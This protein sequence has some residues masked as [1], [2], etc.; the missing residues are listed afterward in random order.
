MNDSRYWELYHRGSQAL[1]AARVLEAEEAF[2]QA[3]LEASLQELHPLVDRAWCNWAAVRFER[4][5]TAG[6]QDGL[7]R[8][9]GTSADLKARQLAAYNLAVQLRAEDRTRPARLYA[10]MAE[11]QAAELGDQRSRAACLHMLGLL[12]IDEGRLMDAREHFTIALEISVEEVANPH[13]FVSM[14]SLGAC[15]TFLGRRSGSLWLLE[16]SLAMATDL[17]ST[18][19]EPAL[20]LNLGFARL[21]WGDL[22]EAIAHG[23]S[24]LDLLDGDDAE[25][26]F[27]LYLL[28]E[29]HA[30]R[31]DRPEAERYLDS[32]QKTY[33]PDF[34]E[35]V[36]FLLAHPTH[37]FVNWLRR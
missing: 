5:E 24:A 6:I 3:W 8:V 27:A 17:G 37:R 19:Y 9:L 1:A 31:G 20:R 13:T 23:R 25:V 14:T 35:V 18:F 16:E 4:G 26:K 32:F 15:L 10:G 11:R 7:M 22:D 21:E 2:A 30:R 28:G 36:P 12:E 29:A 33:Y 34:P